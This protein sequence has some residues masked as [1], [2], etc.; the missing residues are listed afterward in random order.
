MCQSVNIDKWAVHKPISYSQPFSNNDGKGDGN[1]GLAP[2]IVSG[3]QSYTN[4]TTAMKAII[5]MCIGKTDDWDYT[6]PS[7]GASSPYRLGDFDGYRNGSYPPF[8]MN[9]NKVPDI[10]VKVTPIYNWKATFGDYLNGIAILYSNIKLL[11]DT[12]WY[13]WMFYSNRKDFQTFNYARSESPFVEGSSGGVGT[14]IT[15]A[16][17]KFFVFCLGNKQGNKFMTIPNSFNGARICDYPISAMLY[18]SMFVESLSG[19]TEESRSNIYIGGIGD[20][21]DLNELLF[22]LDD[23]GEVYYVYG[24]KQDGSNDGIEIEFRV[25][26]LDDSY[27]DLSQIKLNYGGVDYSISELYIDGSISGALQYSKGKAIDLKFIFKNIFSAH[28]CNST[29]RPTEVDCS[30]KLDGNSI[31]N[32][33]YLNFYVISSSVLGTTGFAPYKFDRNN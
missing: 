19:N 33:N 26:P 9:Y 27:Y 16:G 28:E 2:K 17:Y 22:S 18:Y 6:R 29:S 23:N 10:N 11:N 25:T 8:Y 31:F 20:T 32:S 24:L 7:G 12:E 3:D 4:D 30:L 1:Y 21:L 14:Q 13:L 5:D 15:S